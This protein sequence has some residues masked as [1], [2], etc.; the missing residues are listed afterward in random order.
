M[1]A[2][3]AR[4]PRI[5]EYKLGHWEG[6]EQGEEGWVSGISKGNPRKGITF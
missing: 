5:G 4:F 1:G 6:G 2:V 3:K